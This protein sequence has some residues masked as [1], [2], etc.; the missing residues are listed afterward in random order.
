VKEQRPEQLSDLIKSLVLAGKS[1]D[2]ATAACAGLSHTFRL[3]S[4]FCGQLSLL[5]WHPLPA[6]QRVEP[7]ELARKSPA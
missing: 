6:S 3:V 4:Y 7:P 2:F 1:H 5:S